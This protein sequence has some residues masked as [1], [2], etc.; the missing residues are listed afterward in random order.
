MG[1]YCCEFHGFYFRAVTI[2]PML[3]LEWDCQSGSEITGAAISMT[4]WCIA[5]HLKA[6]YIDATGQLVEIFLQ[7]TAGLYTETKCEEL[8]VSKSSPLCPYERIS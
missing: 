1:S 8:N 5:L 3:R 6:G 2:I 4:V 7:R